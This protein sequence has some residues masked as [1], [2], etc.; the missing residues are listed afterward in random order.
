[1]E[2]LVLKNGIITNRGIQIG[3]S[4]KLLKEKYPSI[5]KVKDG[6]TDD[7][8]CSYEIADRERYCYLRFEVNKGIV[9][10]IRLFHELP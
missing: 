1:M 7:N 4:I 8:N 6:R 2:I 3:D 10:Q 9:S 5:S